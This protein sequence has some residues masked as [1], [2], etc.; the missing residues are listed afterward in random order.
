MG[1]GL[2]HVSASVTCVQ[3]GFRALRFDFVKGYA[4]RFQTVGAPLC[5]LRLR[6]ADSAVSHQDYV[7]AAGEPFAVAENWNG[8]VNGSR[9]EKVS[10]PQRECKVEQIPSSIHSRCS[11]SSSRAI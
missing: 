2:K 8:D 7:K 11:P 1:C 10:D 5:R 4:P 6:L 3:I 9:S